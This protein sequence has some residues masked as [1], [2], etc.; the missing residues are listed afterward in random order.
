[1][2]ENEVLHYLQVRMRQIYTYFRNV[3]ILDKT[4]NRVTTL[5]NVLC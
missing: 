3:K 5:R 4:V 2:Q 1:M